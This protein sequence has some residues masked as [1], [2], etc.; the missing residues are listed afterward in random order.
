MD[1]LVFMTLQCHYD[2]RPQRL[3]DLLSLE[4]SRE[5]QAKIAEREIWILTG[6]YHPCGDELFFFGQ[7]LWDP[8]TT[9]GKPEA[10]TEV[11]RLVWAYCVYALWRA[12]G[13]QKLQEWI[14]ETPEGEN[15]SGIC[16]R[17]SWVMRDIKAWN[18]KKKGYQEGKQRG[19]IRGLNR[20]RFAGAGNSKRY[21]E[22]G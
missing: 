10:Y 17:D 7:C 13:L 12:P 4:F 6:C 19:S 21:I 2:E 5:L 18:N 20:N 16:I 22:C 1:T 11:V 8:R 3:A 14:Q 9:S 15:G